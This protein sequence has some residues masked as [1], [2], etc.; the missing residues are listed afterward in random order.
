MIRRIVEAPTR[1]P[2]SSSSPWILTF[3][4]RGCQP[5]LALVTT[6]YASRLAAGS[7]LLKRPE[8]LWPV[9][10]LVFSCVMIVVVADAAFD[11]L[12]EAE[13]PSALGMRDRTPRL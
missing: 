1:R 10:M 2:S 6:G 13:R 12:G 9:A 8:L 11:G 5:R 4:R 7:G 3:P